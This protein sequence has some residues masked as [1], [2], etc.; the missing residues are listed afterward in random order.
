MMKSRMIKSAACGLG[1]ALLQGCGGRTS[2]DSVVT[3]VGNPVGNPA[4]PVEATLDHFGNALV[5]PGTRVV[6]HAEACGECGHAYQWLRNGVSIPGATGG[7]LTLNIPASLTDLDARCSGVYQAQVTGDETTNLTAPFVLE[8]A[9]RAWVVTQTADSGPGTLREALSQA[10]G[11]QGITGIQFDLPEPGPQVI[12]IASTLP[13]ITTS[14]TILGP[15]AGSVTVDGADVHRPFFVNGGTLVLNGFTVANGLGKGGDAPGGGGGAAGMG[16]GLF[17]NRGSVTL[18]R[19]AFQGNR[20]Q[21]GS[22]GFGLDGEN[23]GGAGFGGDSPATGGKGAGGG[24]LG[25]TGGEGYLDGTEAG[26]GPAF[27]GDG[28]GGGAA[29]GGLLNQALALWSDNE[30]GGEGNWGGGGGFSV[31][32]LGGGGSGGFGGGGGASGGRI[33]LNLGALPTPLLLPGASRGPSGFFGGDGSK[34]DGILLAGQGG[35]GGGM[36]GAIFLRRGGLAMY[37]CRFDGNHA[38]PGTGAE[39]GLGKG[40]AVFVYEYDLSRQA[41]F[42]LAVLQAQQFG[43]NTASDPVEDP[44]YD[45]ND[46]YVAQTSLARVTRASSLTQVYRDYRQTRRQGLVWTQRPSVAAAPVEP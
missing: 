4:P 30:A 8:E 15:A 35:G 26:G 21:G 1:L 9:D 42:D 13:A 5:L 40:G 36:G 20:A 34:G 38:L 7:T 12:Q 45:N 18:T 39:P 46:Y 16:G 24:L 29:R 33:T 11:L 10:D 6:L 17:I 32:P 25:A 31:G 41:G 14:V 23:G 19:M 44:A 43:G 27:N 2:C 28:G 22:S 3:P 37:Q